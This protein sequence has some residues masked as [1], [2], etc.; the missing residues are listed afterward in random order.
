MHVCCN[1]NASLIT[2][3]ISLPL[4]V[5]VIEILIFF[6]LMMGQGSWVQVQVEL[7]TVISL[8]TSTVYTG[9]EVHNVKWLL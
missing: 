3:R 1:E 4:F 9:G 6:P 8:S 2:R 5:I 7:K